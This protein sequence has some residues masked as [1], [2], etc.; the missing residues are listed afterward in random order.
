M[1]GNDRLVIT[2][3]ADFAAL[4]DGA[5]L[6][7]GTGIDTLL[8]VSGGSVKLEAGSITGIERIYARGGGS[9]DMSELTKG[10]NVISQSTDT[11]SAHVIGSQEADRIHAGE[12]GDTIAGGKGG[13]KLFAGSGEDTFHFQDSFGRDNVYGFSTE[14]DHINIHIAGVDAGDIKLA[15]FHDGQ[16][17]IVTF[18]GVDGTNKIILHDVTIADLHAGPSDLF[19]FGA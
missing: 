10:Q 4:D 13:D 6:N 8:F 15:E 12:G 9:L 16:D 1:A 2:G 14:T 11:H 3:N 7:G 18:A 17:T 19:I 5:A